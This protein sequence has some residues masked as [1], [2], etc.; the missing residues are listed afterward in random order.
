MNEEEQLEFR[1]ALGQFATGVTIVTTA[2]PAREPIGVT[3]NSFSSVSLQPPM[4]LWSLAAAAL[5]KKVFEE[6]K[7]F[8]VHVLTASQRELSE[9]F[10]QQGADKFGGTDWSWGERALP[11]LNCYAARFQCRTTTQFP[12]GDHVVFVGEVMKFEKTDE[13]PLVFHGGKY[14]HAERRMI[15]SVAEEIRGRRESD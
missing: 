12:V 15:K 14:A 13:R 11:M 5:S 10:A 9:L 3:A 7:Y 6:A 8:C 1:R 4:V 2:S